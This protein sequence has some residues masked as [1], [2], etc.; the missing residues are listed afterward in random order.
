VLGVFAR[1]IALPRARIVL[2]A[3]LGSDLLLT[4][5]H[6]LGFGGFWRVLIGRLTVRVREGMYRRTNQLGD[7]PLIELFSLNQ[8]LRYSI[9]LVAVFVE[10][11]AGALFGAV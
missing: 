2:L 9:E 11:F 1:E 6:S 3:E 5:R 10:Q 8:L 4:F 7:L